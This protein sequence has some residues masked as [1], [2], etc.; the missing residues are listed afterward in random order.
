MLNTEKALQLYKKLIQ[1]YQCKILVGYIEKHH[2]VPRCLGGSDD[3]DNLVEL[4]AK[5]HYVAHHLLHLAYPENRKLA[6]AFGAMVMK[7]N[8]R[9]YTARM[10]DQARKVISISQ[11]GRRRPDLAERNKQGK[12]KKRGPMPDHV[13]EILRKINS[14]RIRL[15]LSEE[16]REKHR[17][18]GKRLRLFDAYNE[19][20][21]LEG[22]TD[23]EIE[24][25]RKAGR[26]RKGVAMSVEGRESY[27]KAAKKRHANAPILRCEK[28]GHSQKRSANFF[29]YH[30]KNCLD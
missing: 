17:Q 26:A 13:K 4:S 23:K 10:Y 5:A 30:G 22:F 16:I 15:P 6:H 29:R 20:K 1:E 12:G 19:R 9:Q 11:T 21:K 2:I 24:N 3:C 28:C 25:K 8:G 7:G 18:N 14:T 27:S